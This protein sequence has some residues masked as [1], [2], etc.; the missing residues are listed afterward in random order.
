MAKYKTREEKISDLKQKEN[1]LRTKRKA[2]ETID[3]KQAKKKRERH[4]IQIGTT[5]EHYFGS[6]DRDKFS[7][8][9]LMRQDMW[10]E[11]IQQTMPE[12]FVVEEPEPPAE[13]EPP[14]EN[15]PA[16]NVA[17]NDEPPIV[18]VKNLEEE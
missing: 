14:A 9:L 7:D 18:E 15:A 17:T 12:V 16:E 1:D 11:D 3:R 10:R 4:M 6:I 13:K 5:F 8:Y 2:L